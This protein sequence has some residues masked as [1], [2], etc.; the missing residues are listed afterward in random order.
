MNG[1]K[2]TIIGWPQ[3][4]RWLTRC[5]LATP[6]V[7]NAVHYCAACYNVSLQLSYIEGR[8]AM[9]EKVAKRR[10]EQA[11][12]AA[13]A[14]A[15]TSNQHKP[16]AELADIDALAAE[17]EALGSGSSSRKEAAAAA[18]GKAKKSKKQDKQMKQ[19]QKKQQVVE[20]WQV[21]EQRLDEPWQQLCAT[22]QL[23]GQQRCTAD[24]G[25]VFE[26]ELT[27]DS[28]EGSAH[29]G[30]TPNHLQQQQQQQ[31]RRGQQWEQ[32]RQRNL[33]PVTE[34]LQRTHRA[35]L[36]QRFCVVIGC[37]AVACQGL[38][39]AEQAAV[40]SSAAD[41]AAP[42]LL[43]AEVCEVNFAAVEPAAAAVT[44]CA[45]SANKHQAA[46]ANR[47]SSKAD[48]ACTYVSSPAVA[49]PVAAH[50]ASDA[51]TAAA[52]A[53]LQGWRSSLN[54]IFLYN[55]PESSSS[56]NG[57]SSID[58]N[59][60]ITTTSSSSSSSSSSWSSTQQQQQQQQQQQRLQLLPP[61]LAPSG[62]TQVPD[63]SPTAYMA[64]GPDAV[65]SITRSS[66]P[67]PSTRKKCIV[68]MERARDVLLLPCKHFKL[69]SACAEQM[70]ARG[71]LDCCPYCRQ[72]CSMQQVYR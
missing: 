35:R 10:K 4:K 62:I 19:K 24:Y 45:A 48:E 39:A 47:V 65:A 9:A 16:L 66:N 8:L 13:A 5:Y 64:S 56:S 14:K 11:A 26:L 49:A 2:L 69:C 12:A 1:G 63:V 38:V 15:G 33:R 43:Q 18:P 67:K 34:L 3:L 52:P 44:S 27:A 61:L 72:P 29:A 25:V 54:P 32:K 21:D 41:S 51:R 70:A 30:C 42:G 20:A 46:A 6:Q 40:S 60:G 23:E 59:T 36:Q 7:D 50:G 71:A 68:C 57:S 22:A 28:T 58:G 17:I 55:R 53:V 37:Y 31:Q